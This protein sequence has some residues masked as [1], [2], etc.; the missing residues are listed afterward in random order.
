MR[1]IRFLVLKVIAL[2]GLFIQLQALTFTVT[3]RDF[4]TTLWEEIVQTLV[5][6]QLINNLEQFLGLLSNP[7]YDFKKR[8]WLHTETIGQQQALAKLYKHVELHESV[9][10][11][12]KLQNNPMLPS[13]RYSVRRRLPLYHGVIGMREFN[14][15]S[16][17][18]YC[19]TASDKVNNE[20][21][22]HIGHV[23]R[24]DYSLARHCVHQCSVGI[25]FLALWSITD[26]PAF[27]VL[28]P[29]KF[30]KGH[31]TARFFKQCEQE[32]V[33]SQLLKLAL[34]ILRVPK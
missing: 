32:M 2:L 19:A 24:L 22:P 14:P 17:T 13:S 6:H 16:F 26:F 3:Y 27:S 1:N 29:V 18:Y 25:L 4:C 33:F 28:K 12:L 8:Y 20:A 34:M 31:L 10:N 9:F 5:A 21:L 11:I 30:Q 23:K 7:M 15:N